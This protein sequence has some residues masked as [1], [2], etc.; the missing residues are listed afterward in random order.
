[1]FVC[2]FRP[3]IVLKGAGVAY[4]EDLW[5]EV[6]IGPSPQ[7]PNTLEGLSQNMTIVDL[8]GRCLVRLPSFLHNTITYIDWYRQ[9]PNVDS[10]TG[11]RDAA[12]PYKVIIKYGNADSAK[13]PMFGTYAVPEGSG[14]VRVGDKVRVTKWIEDEV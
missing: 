14:V 8:C 4:A 13:K 3:N 10:Q 7:A 11:E 2:R 12:V 5:R 9:L 1:M 6:T